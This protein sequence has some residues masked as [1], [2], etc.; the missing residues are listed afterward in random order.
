MPY[1]LNALILLREVLVESLAVDLDEVVVGDDGA[2]VLAERQN[3]LVFEQLVGAI[4]HL[5]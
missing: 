3:V 4:F 5:F 2:G 1:V